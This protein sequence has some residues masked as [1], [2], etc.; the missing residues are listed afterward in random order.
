[1]SDKMVAARD[2]VIEQLRFPQRA[3]RTTAVI[4]WPHVS[5][6]TQSAVADLSDTT[7]LDANEL[8]AQPSWW[9]SITGRPRGYPQLTTR[10]RAELQQAHTSLH[11]PL[12]EE[13]PEIRLVAV[14]ENVVARLVS[15]PAWA[16]PLLDGHRTILGFTIELQMFAAA[17][18]DLFR[19]RAN[20]P[21]APVNDG[22][23]HLARARAE[24]ERRQV[25][26]AKAEAGL[27]DRAA[28]L[29]AYEDALTP[30]ATSLTNLRAIT[31]MTAGGA[32][33]DRLYAGIVD[34]E[35]AVERTSAL[36]NDIDD[37]R[38]GLEAQVNY[39]DSLIGPHRNA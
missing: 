33:V 11:W 5:T 16:H 37:I 34:A 36:R 3:P 6:T 8:V 12:R 22:T 25:V 29:R 35:Y 4:A 19:L 13:G 24:W 20:T 26:A 18:H 2:W 28:A 21:T 15:H 7:I 23:D 27:I 30:I 32:D 9:R 38:A 1:M 10:Q 14:V 39:L 17:A 31:E